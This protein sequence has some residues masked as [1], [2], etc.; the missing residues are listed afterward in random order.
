MKPGYLGPGG[1]DESQS[2]GEDFP[3][4]ELEIFTEDVPIDLKDSLLETPDE[5]SILINNQL[6]KSKLQNPDITPGI[7]K[8]NTVYAERAG[9]S[10]VFQ[11][12]QKSRDLYPSQDKTEIY[13]LTS[14]T[15]QNIPANFQN[16]QTSTVYG[17]GFF[18]RNPDKWIGGNNILKINN[19]KYG[20]F[21]LDYTEAVNPNVQRG[22]PLIP[23]DDFN[24]CYSQ[25]T[26]EETSRITTF[27]MT[28]LGFSFSACAMWLDNILFTTDNV[29]FRVVGDYLF[30]A[31]NPD[32]T[33]GYAFSDLNLD[34]VTTIVSNG[35][36]FTFCFYGGGGVYDGTD[37][38]A[39][40]YFLGTWAENITQVG[41]IGIRFTDLG[42]PDGSGRIKP[43]GEAGIDFFIPLGLD[44]LKQIPS[45]FIPP[46]GDGATI[47]FYEILSG[48]LVGPMLF[49]AVDIVTVGNPRVS[50]KVREDITIRGLPYYSINGTDEGGR[51]ANTDNADSNAEVD[52]FLSLNWST[53]IPT[54]IQADS[55][56]VRRTAFDR[57]ADYCRRNEYYVGDETDY[58]KQQEDS[59][60]WVVDLDVGYADDFNNAMS[61][62]LSTQSYSIDEDDEIPID[63]TDYNIY[64]QESNYSHILPYYST[65]YSSKQYGQPGPPLHFFTANGQGMNYIRPITIYPISRYAQMGCNY[66]SRDNH[67]VVHSRYHPSY[68]DVKSQYCINRSDMVTPVSKNINNTNLGQQPHIQMPTFKILLDDS[69][70]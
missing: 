28:T 58:V 22:E 18:V 11:Y 45:K 47:E 20:V 9:W 66:I 2:G 36:G 67:V 31:L 33:Q 53:I 25:P 61:N 62:Y 57:I 46:K 19:R 35:D 26:G 55:G 13:N 43:T 30:N 32:P 70:N 48:D 51:L 42:Q 54:N 44:A 16:D 69:V 12:S 3:F 23:T 6:Q 1:R 40:K 7:I 65:L 56:I 63:Q 59:F 64:G 49:E 37:Y 24:A 8:K 21:A 17:E 52:E 14:P 60:N 15:L 10:Y 38:G 34:G 41:Q 39:D 50:F 5:I 4:G 68:Y 29:E 27:L